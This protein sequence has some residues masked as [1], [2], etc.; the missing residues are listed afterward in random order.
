MLGFLL[1]T[2]IFISAVV[3]LSFV[4]NI[5]DVKKNWGKY[6]CRPD[7][8]IM[9]NIYGFS[10]IDNLEFCLKN[11]F[12][13]RAASAITPFYTYLASFTGILTTLLGSINSIRMT[14]ATLVGSTTTVFSNFSQRIQALLYRIQMTA[15]RMKFMMSRVF[16]TMYSVIFM[17]MS[18]I[19]AGQNFS[20]TFL[21]TFLDAFCFDPDTPIYVKGMGFIPIKDVKNGHVLANDE[22]VTST[23]KFHADGQ[24]MVVLPGQILVS[25]NHY[26]LHNGS[27][28]KAEFHPDAQPAD[29]WNGGIERPLIC[30]NTTTHS[31]TVGKYIFRDYDETSAGDR[32]SMEAAINM[33]NGCSKTEE[34]SNALDSTMACSPDTLLKLKG[35][36]RKNSPGVIAAQDVLLGTELSHG[37]V[38]GIVDKV[39]TAKCV[40][41]G[42]TLAPGTAVW[43]GNSW[44]RVSD[45]VKSEPI[46]PTIYRSF[47]VTSAVVETNSGLLFRDYVEVHDPDME[48]PYA[49]SLEEGITC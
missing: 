26:L 23:F 43:S 5:Q 6:R 3:C 40:Y 19:K 8:M 38:A 44:R 16:G 1:T 46:P 41:K 34:K 32:E 39:A 13:Q 36:I 11:G 21:W 35:S 22:V 7:V 25:T 27:W 4:L 37:I 9:A 24:R 47:I 2:L 15:I 28:I 42:E 33:L 49:A 48:K 10:A 31:F 18:G 17:G 20:N 45:I 12:D 29:I 30:L 14:F